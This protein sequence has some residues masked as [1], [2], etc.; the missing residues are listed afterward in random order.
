MTKIILPEWTEAQTAPPDD[1]ELLRDVEYGRDG[2]RSLTL[3]ILRPAMSPPAPMP[4][5]VGIHGGGWAGGTKDWCLETLMHFAARG[6]FTVA[7]GHQF[8]REA[9]FPSMIQD[10][11]CAVRYLRANANKYHLDSA[12]IGA[13]G[14]SSGGHLAAL[15]GTAGHVTELEGAGGWPD[16]SSRVQAVCDWFG[17]S[18]KFQD[19]PGQQNRFD[20][21]WE[22]FGGTLRQNLDLDVSFDPIEHVTPTAPPF[23]IMHGDKDDF[24]PLKASERLYDALT[25]SGVE[26]TLVIAQGAGHGLVRYDIHALMLR[27]F[28]QHLRRR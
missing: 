18:G 15:L 5:L 12:H 2:G 16:Q 25:S 1:L 9:P 14:F 21:H 20:E 17:P 8:Q 22:L 7:V 4:V 26:A 10:C 24:V 3:H 28:D 19:D 6:Y 11:K 23:L 27:F 13:W